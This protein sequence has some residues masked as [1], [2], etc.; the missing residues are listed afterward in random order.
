MPL[1]IFTW[2][3]AL[4]AGPVMCTVSPGSSRAAVVFRF[5]MN[6]SMSE[7]KP[8]LDPTIV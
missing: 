3:A 4:A 6:P 5:L 7:L 1:K 8:R 2:S